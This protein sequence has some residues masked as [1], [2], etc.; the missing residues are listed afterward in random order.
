MIQ[1]FAHQGGR[2][3]CALGGDD[4]TAG[5]GGHEGGRHG[6]EGDEEGDDVLHGVIGLFELTT[7]MF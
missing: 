2:G 3:T 1:N 4:A 7:T 6:H 5:G